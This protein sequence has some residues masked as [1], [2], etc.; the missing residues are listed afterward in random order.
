MAGLFTVKMI[1]NGIDIT[2]RCFVNSDGKV[3]LDLENAAD[4]AEY[5]VLEDFIDDVTNLVTIEF[6]AD[7][8]LAKL[9]EA[10]N[11]MS[12]ELNP[13]RMGQ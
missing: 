5:S 11:L 7:T 6:A 4:G 2:D 9:K 10:N 13:D 3:F 12:W 1:K 8:E